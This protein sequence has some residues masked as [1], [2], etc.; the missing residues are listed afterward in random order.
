MVFSLKKPRE[1]PNVEPKYLNPPA[2]VE[3]EKFN[4]KCFLKIACFVIILVVQIFAFVLYFKLR[5]T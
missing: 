1:D 3:V 5:G 2:Y 4:V